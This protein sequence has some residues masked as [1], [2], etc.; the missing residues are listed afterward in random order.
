MLSHVKMAHFVCLFLPSSSSLAEWTHFLYRSHQDSFLFGDSSHRC[1]GR[2]SGMEKGKKDLIR[3]GPGP[4]QTALSLDPWGQAAAL[5]QQVQ[6]SVRPRSRIWVEVAVEKDPAGL[7]GLQGPRKK[8][9]VPLWALNGFFSVKTNA[10]LVRRF[11][12]VFALPRDFLFLLLP[13]AQPQA[14]H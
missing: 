11:V 13:Q 3:P 12:C 5:S 9:W 2:E 7:P 8:P 10:G 1:G 14:G 6:G 4:E